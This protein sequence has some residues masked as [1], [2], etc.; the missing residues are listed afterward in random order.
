MLDIGLFDDNVFSF[1]K[2]KVGN[3]FFFLC[4]FYENADGLFLFPMALYDQSSKSIVR[5]LRTDPRNPVKTIRQDANVP[6]FGIWRLKSI[7]D[8]KRIYSYFEWNTNLYVVH[9]LPGVFNSKFDVIDY[10]Q[11]LG[12]SICDFEEFGQEFFVKFDFNIEPTVNSLLL[13]RSDFE[14]FESSYRLKKKLLLLN[15]TRLV[16]GS[17]FDSF[18]DVHQRKISFYKY[19]QI[20]E[21]EIVRVSTQSEEKICLNAIT[22]YLDDIYKNKNKNTATKNYVNAFSEFLQ[23]FTS[24]KFSL[25]DLESK[26]G[27]S[28]E[29][30]LNKIGE[31]KS[32]LEKEQLT[33]DERLIKKIVE[34][35]ENIRKDFL[36]IVEKNYEEEL[37]VYKDDIQK[38]ASFLKVKQ[39]EKSKLEQEILEIEQRKS[40]LIQF[41]DSFTRSFERK[42]DE[43][44][45]S[46][47]EALSAVM[48]N[49]SILN[50]GQNSIIAEN[51]T[52]FVK[53]SFLTEKSNIEAEIDSFSTLLK[54]ARNR[55]SKL[56]IKS[57]LYSD[58][59]ISTLYSCDKLHFNLILCGTYSEQIAHMYSYMVYGAKAA[60]LDCANPYDPSVQDIIESLKAKVIV[61]KNPFES[62]WIDKLAT[63][64]LLSEKFLILTHPFVE[65]LAIEPSSV[66]SYFVP[67]FTNNFIDLSKA[68]SSTKCVFDRLKPTLY[69]SIDNNS[70]FM[71][72]QISIEIDLASRKLLLGNY[73]KYE[74][75]AKTI[76]GYY[77]QM[78]SND[79]ISLF[80]VPMLFATGR[81][82]EQQLN[83]IASKNSS[84]KDLNEILV[85]DND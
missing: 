33:F 82:S 10:L 3:E 1:H 68:I 66:Y 8:S 54:C 79:F 4:E 25:I 84:L 28:Q 80:I 83:M 27:L 46:V 29:K 6:E 7:Q 58:V 61:V 5:S 70:D 78:Q 9:T 65:D 64:S 55:F 37:K 31:I 69:C 13:K 57:A 38:E 85:L 56:N 23:D 14:K 19:S 43:L 42:L 63:I 32:F 49:R 35:N 16:E 17:N 41:V 34:N 73:D 77:S 47:P 44:K 30:L 74:L 48:F 20:R 26:T 39:E 45:K 72:N 53:D 59:L 21:D 50:A 71:S 24:Q 2:F 36:S 76:C 52:P 22:K 40:S 81:I 12:I 62:N 11:N 67:I 51:K 75:L 60:I 15:G 18:N